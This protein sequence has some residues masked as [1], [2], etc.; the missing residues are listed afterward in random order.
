MS[1]H[2]SWGWH[3]S[4]SFPIRASPNFWRAFKLHLIQRWSHMPLSIPISFSCTFVWGASV[5]RTR[6]TFI[7]GDKIKVG[8]GEQTEAWLQGKTVSWIRSLAYLWYKRT[9]KPQNGHWIFLQKRNKSS[10]SAFRTSNRPLDIGTPCRCRKCHTFWCH[11]PDIKYG[12]IQQFKTDWATQK[13][14]SAQSVASVQKL[15]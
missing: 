10:N 7:L 14:H 13:G 12:D 3:I 11:K 1:G 6:C 5:L 4:Y 9:L 15:N 2:G 8:G